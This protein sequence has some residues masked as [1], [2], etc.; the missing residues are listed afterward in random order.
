[1]T[2]ASSTPAIAPGMAP[3]RPGNDA[4]A[5]VVA[6][7]LSAGEA[8]RQQHTDMWLL[9]V[10]HAADHDVGRHRRCRQEHDGEEDG[11][12][13]EPLEVLRQGGV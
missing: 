5:E 8:V 3:A 13:L 12:L 9:G 6:E 4:V 7:D 10:N 1:M 2:R 11:Q